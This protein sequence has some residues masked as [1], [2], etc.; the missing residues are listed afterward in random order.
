MA[1]HPLTTAV[2]TCA[3]RLAMRSI[4]LLAAIALAAQPGPASARQP[5][6]TSS[7]TIKF[8]GPGPFGGQCIDR[9]ERDQHLLASRG[10]QMLGGGRARVPGTSWRSMRHWEQSSIMGSVA[11]QTA[12]AGLRP[13]TVDVRIVDERDRTLRDQRISTSL[14][15]HGDHAEI[16]PDEVEY[17][18]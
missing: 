11:W 16:R 3:I 7:S 15:C 18:C 4:L 8:T 17:P 5:S 13:I 14:E 12:C 6:P 10:I 9:A 2:S 1:M